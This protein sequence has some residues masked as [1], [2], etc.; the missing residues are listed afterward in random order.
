[1]IFRDSA[2]VP[3]DETPIE[4][5]IAAL[6]AADARARESLPE[7]PPGYHWR[8]TLE[9]EGID[10]DFA[11]RGADAPAFARLTYRLQSDRRG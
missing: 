1:M 9:F 6:K 10:H 3:H 8:A 5:T 4:Q 7:S 11:T 2:S